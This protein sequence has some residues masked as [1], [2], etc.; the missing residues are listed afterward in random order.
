MSVSA[1]L[2]GAIEA[3]QRLSAVWNIERDKLNDINQSCC[4]ARVAFEKQEV[5]V[6]GLVA[7]ELKKQY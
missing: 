1:M 6:R 2:I 4:D 3:A 7:K 5:I